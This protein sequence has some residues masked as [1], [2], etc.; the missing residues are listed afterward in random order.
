[1]IYMMCL[2]LIVFVFLMVLN[3]YLQGSRKIQIDIILKSLVAIIIIS[4][5]FTEG[6]V[7]GVMLI[8]VVFVSFVF[9]RPVAANIVSKIFAM[10]DGK[11]NSKYV[12]LPSR[13]L[14]RI[15]QMLGKW[16][17]ED[18]INELVNYCYKKPD[19]YVLLKKNNISHQELHKIYKRLI[20]G[21]AGQWVCGHWVAASALAY[22]K[23]LE[24]ILSHNGEITDIIVISLIK[25]FK[26]GYP[27]TT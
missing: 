8:G 25:Y 23:S 19:I 14:N 10:L 18:V 7:F 1:M 15:S 21:L 26:T 13:N 27:L 4:A 12:G 9:F 17:K 6:W 3:G 20:D 11:G 5:F 22:P 24:Y 2:A 16:P